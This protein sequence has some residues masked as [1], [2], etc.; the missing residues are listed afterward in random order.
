MGVSAP[1]MSS[2]T[3]MRPGLPGASSCAQ[4]APLCLSHAVRPDTFLTDS[5]TATCSLSQPNASRNRAKYSTSMVVMRESSGFISGY[6]PQ[7]AASAHLAVTQ[8]ESGDAL[9]VVQ[10]EPG[11]PGFKIDIGCNSDDMRVVGMQQWRCRGAPVDLD[12]GN[13]LLL[14]TLPHAPIAG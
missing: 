4:G 6:Y 14:E 9:I 11:Q 7:L 12:L 8:D 10:P 5:G 3:A 1:A 2:L 13:R